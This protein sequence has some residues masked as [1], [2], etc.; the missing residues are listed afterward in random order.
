MRDTQSHTKFDS[1]VRNINTIL[2]PNIGNYI[3]CQVIILPFP[4]MLLLLV[5]LSLP[6]FIFASHI[7]KTASPR[8]V[9]RHIKKKCTPKK[10]KKMY[11]NHFF[12]SIFGQVNFIES[13]YRQDLLLL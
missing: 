7:D 2:M 9:K 3:H 11:T 6:N 5:F 10:K 12:E 13:I 4:A 1:L 8:N